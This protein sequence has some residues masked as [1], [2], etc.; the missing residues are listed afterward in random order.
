VRLAWIIL[1][2]EIIFRLSFF[3][4][5]FT[6]RRFCSRIYL[7]YFY[8]RFLYFYLYFCFYR[9][10]PF[11]LRIFDFTARGL[12][13]IYFIARHL[14]ITLLNPHEFDVSYSYF[15]SPLRATVFV[16]CLTR[17][18]LPDA[19]EFVQIRRYVFC[20]LAK[21]PHLNHFKTTNFTRLHSGEIPLCRRVREPALTP[22]LRLCR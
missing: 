15:L 8:L 12:R 1:F 11:L 21:M 22:R 13:E 14:L 4:L 9:K 20:R 16:A 18:L 2:K 10:S 5:N 7:P 19:S 3:C 17:R 6:F